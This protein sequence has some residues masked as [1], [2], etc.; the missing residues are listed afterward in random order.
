MKKLPPIE[1]LKRL[2]HY[3][4]DTGILTWKVSTSNRVRAGDEPGRLLNDGYKQLGVC[5]KRFATHRVCYAIYHG[6]DPHPMQVDHINHDRLDNRIDNLRLV[7]N[8]ENHK[9]RSKSPRNTSGVTGVYWHK[10]KNKWHAKIK[11]NGKNKH[12]GYFTNKADAIAA[13]R[14]AEK[15]YGFH[16]NHG[17]WEDQQPDTAPEMKLALF[18]PVAKRPQQERRA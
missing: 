3:D 15:K 10:Q 9:N 18:V 17:D 7:S 4:P 16:E 5:G 13:R 6:V 8:Q 1:E 12:I 11:S 14:A 2:F